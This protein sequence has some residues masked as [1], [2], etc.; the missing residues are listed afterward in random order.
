[1]SWIK[2]LRVNADPDIVITLIGNKIDLCET[3]KDKRQVTKEEA[4]AFARKQH[5]EFEETSAH[6]NLNVDSAFLN[7]IQGMFRNLKI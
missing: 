5:L 6:S 3:D 7:L 2:D 1:M 4:E